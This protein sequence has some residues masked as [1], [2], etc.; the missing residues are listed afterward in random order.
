LV[1][2]FDLFHRDGTSPKDLARAPINAHRGEFLACL[3]ELCQE[4]T[5]RPND[6]RRQS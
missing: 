2:L 6:W 4:D 5:F 3:I 1:D